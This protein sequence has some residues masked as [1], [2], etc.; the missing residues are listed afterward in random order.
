MPCG[1]HAAVRC[2]AEDRKALEQ[3]CRYITRPA[4]ANERVRCNA[5][6]QVVLKLKT[7]RRDGITHLVFAAEFLQLTNEWPVCGGQILWFNACNGSRLASRS[8]E[9]A[10]WNPSSKLMMR[11]S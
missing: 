7:R 4:M 1:L 2:D 11:V 3:L 6:G 5:A 10:A 8:G 9:L